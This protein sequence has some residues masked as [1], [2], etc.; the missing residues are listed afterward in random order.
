MLSSSKIAN[1]IMRNN[2]LMRSIHLAKRV[3]PHTKRPRASFFVRYCGRYNLG[4]MVIAFGIA[5]ALACL[6]VLFA[7]VGIGSLPF[8]PFVIEDNL[9]NL[10]ALTWLAFLVWLWVSLVKVARIKPETRTSDR[11]LIRMQIVFFINAAVQAILAFFSGLLYSE[12]PDWQSLHEVFLVFDWMII[13]FHTLYFLL[14]WCVRA[15]VPI[16]KFM[17]FIL[18]LSITVAHTMFS[19]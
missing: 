15:P 3:Y 18:M 12:P 14:A 7:G 9:G 1:L 2:L 10:L 4:E 8:L 17:T 6:I 5:G 19:H 16:R 13:S 11:D